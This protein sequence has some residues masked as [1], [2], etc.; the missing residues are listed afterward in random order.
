MRSAARERGSG[1]LMVMFVIVLLTGVGIVLLSTTQTE[2]KTARA[3]VFSKRA[4]YYAEAGMEDS[5][6]LLRQTNA[7]DTVAAHRK[8]FT[9]ELVAAAGPNGTLDMN[10]DLIRA[11][12]DS[13]GRP[14]TFTGAGDDVP[15]K[16][17]T[18]FA[19]GAYAAYLSND[20]AEGRH[21]TVDANG[22]ALITAIGAGPDSSFLITEAVVEPF[23]IPAF[24]S[25]ITLLGP[26]PAFDGG[27]SNAKYY[28]GND[29]PG[30]TGDYWPAVGAVGPSA[31]AEAQ[32]GVKKPANYTAGPWT[33][34]G[35]VQDITSTMDP[36]VERLQVLPRAVE[37]DPGFRRSRRRLGH[38]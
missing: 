16:G 34:T 3:D 37:D 13:K 18:A 14:T 9:D 5:R 29:C 6:E 17:F 15:I 32:A 30:A 25:T 23:D 26:H 4:F 11:T 35:T 38:A 21:N 36:L 1:F 7:A 24:P 10:P 31:T 27:M 33:G 28:T 19:Q 8:T 2:V 12:F 20:P 22:L